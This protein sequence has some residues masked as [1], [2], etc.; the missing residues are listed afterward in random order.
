MTDAAK[1]RSKGKTTFLPLFLLSLFWTAELF[2]IQ[3]LTLFPNYPFPSD[4]WIARRGIRLILNF[5][6]CSFMILALPRLVLFMAHLAGLFSSLMLLVYFDY[7][8]EALSLHSI[9]YTAGE[10]MAV[11]A[12][13]LEQV[14]WMPALFLTGA[15]FIKVHLLRRSPP[16]SRNLS[17]R[18]KTG[19][20]FLACYLSIV[21]IT[22]MIFDPLRRLGTWGTVGRLGI[23]YGYCVSWLGEAWYLNE[24]RLVQRALKNSIK[25]TDRLSP[26]EPN[27]PLSR[28]IVILQVE[29]LDYHILDFQD[30]SMEVTPFLNKLKRL[31][32]F[33]KIRPIYLRGSADADF[34]MLTGKMPSSDVV[35]YTLRTYPYD[36]DCLPRIAA[37]KGYS[38][39]ALHGNS[40]SFFHRRRAFR[41]MGFYK[42]FFLEELLEQGL[43]QGRWG[44]DDAGVLGFSSFLLNKSPGKNLHFIITLTSHGPFSYLM[45]KDRAL[46][47]DP[48]DIEERYM[49]S[50]HYVDRSIH[51]YVD[52]L[53]AGTLL[54]IYGDHGS[55]LDYFMPG[56]TEDENYVPCFIYKKGEDL[57]PL[58][59]TRHTAVA[60]SGRL[61]IIDINRYL[62]RLF[63]VSRDKP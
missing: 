52:A 33:Y 31:S 30:R 48:S 60:S 29:S 19:A 26:M 44:I 9:I 38:V 58:Q 28:K 12:Y 23:T 46:F 7:F 3:E 63:K 4:Q 20:V 15:F 54:M 57:A 36:A 59:K 51:Q 35:T 17:F 1:N 50:M 47:K 6:G 22:S 21:L 24:D 32:F 49:N 56:G 41:S 8:R 2:I 25:A 61:D 43:S 10:G 55:H 27:I 53:P 45:D 37:S 16:L 62:I 40:G 39:A 11:A 18:L 5:L 13:F 34:A 14:R 42:T